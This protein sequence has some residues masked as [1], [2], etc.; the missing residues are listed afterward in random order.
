[1]NTNRNEKIRQRAYEIGKSEGKPS[2]RE[3]DNWYQASLD[4]EDAP[5]TIFDEYRVKPAPARAVRNK[6]AAKET[7]PAPGE[8]SIR[9]N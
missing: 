4:A 7:P 3:L 8:G 2:G 1:M 6:G 9:G 5:K